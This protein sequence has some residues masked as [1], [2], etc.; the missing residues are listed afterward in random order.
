MEPTA[1]DMLRHAP[2]YLPV[3][4]RLQRTGRS[5]RPRRPWHLRT[6]LTSKLLRRPWPVQEDH[7]RIR[8]ED[9]MSWFE[10]RFRMQ[11]RSWDS[12]YLGYTLIRA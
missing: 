9:L 10:G 5:V 8:E 4:R 2:S 7:L 1:G 6:A 11:V 3:I 12:G